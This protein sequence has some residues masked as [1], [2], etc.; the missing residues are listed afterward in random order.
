M[1]DALLLLAYLLATLARLLRPGGARA[2][3]AENLLRGETRGSDPRAGSGALARSLI[4]RQLVAQYR[5][6]QL[7]G[8]ARAERRRE[9]GEQKQGCLLHAGPRFHEGLDASEVGDRGN[10]QGICAASSPAASNAHKVS[11]R[12]EESSRKSGDSDFREAQVL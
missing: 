8:E 11:L 9:Q 1:K 12:A 5:D 4:H 2:I 7:E 3:A 10:L 6:L